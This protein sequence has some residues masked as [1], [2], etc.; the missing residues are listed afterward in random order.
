[1]TNRKQGKSK[2]GGLIIVL[3]LTGLGAAVLFGWAI[4]TTLDED[5]SARLEHHAQI[6]ADQISADAAH[7]DA[8]ATSSFDRGDNGVWLRRHWIHGGAK[9]DVAELVSVLDG[10]GIRRIYPFL[11]PMD[12]DGKPGWRDEGQVHHYQP[13]QARRFFGK[14]KRLGPHID[15]TPWTGGVL[16]RDV[17]PTDQKQRDAYAGHMANITDLGADGVHINVEP[18]PSQEPGYLELLR[19]VKEAIGAD[20]TLSIA[21]YPPT[22]PLH[23]FPQVHWTLDFTK[24]VCMV[25]DELVV[26]GYDTAL[27]DPTAY[28]G[29]MATWTEDLLETLPAPK[30]GGCEIV[31]GV[32]AYEDD[33]AYHRPNVENIEHGI[34]GVNQG[35][36][37]LDEVP[38]HFRGIAVY[39]SWTTDADEWDTYQKLW[40]GTEPGGMV[41]PDFDL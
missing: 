9:L 4:F 20:K 30:D 5:G 41:L 6:E 25:A 39:S 8:D 13:D 10:L 19:T 7:S 17:R 15:V 28:E 1:M 18:L 24:D 36:E 38:H 11:G 32:P 2:F 26:M 27:T 22:T 35:L 34:R 29:L 37:R 16:D 12:K 23:P 21:A 3:A 14:M 40:R 33:K 31:M